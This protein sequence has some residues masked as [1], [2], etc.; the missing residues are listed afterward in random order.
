M[1][2]IPQVLKLKVGETTVG[3]HQNLNQKKLQPQG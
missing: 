1:S 2:L 3:G